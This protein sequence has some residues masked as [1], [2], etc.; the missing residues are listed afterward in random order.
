[1]TW[2]QYTTM[3]ASQLSP[4]YYHTLSHTV[5]DHVGYTHNSAFD[6]STTHRSILSDI[7]TGNSIPTIIGA[8]GME[9]KEGRFR[10][11]FPANS[12]HLPAVPTPTP[13]S[14]RRGR[15]LFP[16]RCHV[17]RRVQGPRVWG[18]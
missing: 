11:N 4:L 16:R 10:V 7:K 17:A 9:T 12:R 13:S 14:S 1:M 3:E 6:W 15:S 18:L 5:H 8:E 2:H